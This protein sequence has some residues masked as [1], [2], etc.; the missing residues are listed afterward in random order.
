M[1]LMNDTENLFFFS[2]VIFSSS[3]LAL[4]GHV[5]CYF[6]LPTNFITLDYSSEYNSWELKSHMSA[7]ALYM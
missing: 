6:A 7:L 5:P 4:A 2:V 3:L 1:N